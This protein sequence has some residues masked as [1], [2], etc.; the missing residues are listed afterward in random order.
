[1]Q[2]NN[3][4]TVDRASFGVPDSENAGIDLFHR[5]ERRVRS[6]LDRGQ[7]HRFCVD[8]L[9]IRSADG[10][11]LGGGDRHGCGAKKA[12]ALPVDCLGQLDRRH[13]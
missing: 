1:V 2:K 9:R 7:I 11:E 5:G 8:G 4:R 3:R 12:A 13:L 6:W 10:A